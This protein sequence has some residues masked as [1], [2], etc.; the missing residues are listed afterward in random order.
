MIIYLVTREGQA[1]ILE[2]PALSEGPVASHFEVVTYEDALRRRDWTEGTV[3]FSDVERFWPSQFQPY[4]DLWRRLRE[5]QP[6]C[7]TLNH[8]PRTLRRYGLL[9]K[10]HA[11]GINS[12]NVYRAD[13]QR[14]SI[15]FPVFLHGER[16]HNGPLS[17]L[18]PDQGALDRTL[19]RLADAGTDLSL[20]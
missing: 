17:P 7:H 3:I 6:A 10:L 16:D 8:P 12:F 11:A 9:R 2:K 1:A 14:T 5:A 13:E 20:V 4:T 15:R 19:A 18:L